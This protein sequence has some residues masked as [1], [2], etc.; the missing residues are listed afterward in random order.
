MDFIAAEK[1]LRRLSAD[2]Q[3]LAR[4]YVIQRNKYGEALW[5]VMVLLAPHQDEDAY[6]K[7][8][9]EKQVLMLMG[10]VPGAGVAV[11]EMTLAQQRYKGLE[12]LIDAKGA[13][14]SSLQSLM[15]YAREGGG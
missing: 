5:E 2:Q 1:E 14:I 9:H 13:R 7:V 4:K 12:K 15:R 8:S 3:A 11:K 6:R 10:E